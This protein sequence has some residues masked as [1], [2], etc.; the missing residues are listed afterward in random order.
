[1]D[2]RLVEFELAFLDLPQL[3]DGYRILH[4]S[5]THLDVYPELA[6][7]ARKL[8]RHLETDL[9]L[10]T[11]DI[12]GRPRTPVAVSSGLLA[13]ALGGVRVR[14]RRVA[15]LGNHDPVEMVDALEDMGFEVLIN[16]AIVLERGDERVGLPGL[17]DVNYFYTGAARAALDAPAGGFRIALVHSPEMADHADTAGYALYLYGHTHGGQIAMP[18]GRPIFT[19]LR[20]CRFAASGLWHRDGMT[21]YTSRGL[22]VSG[23]P[24][25]FNTQGEMALITLRRA[26]PPP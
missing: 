4:V 26:S 18:G 11:G 15:V 20:R 6:E 12:H 16:R 2:L 21:G 5:N 10:L 1:M 24:V 9:L 7:A 8:S 22:G 23:P 19:Q 17:D 3:F 14:D 25:R 13:T